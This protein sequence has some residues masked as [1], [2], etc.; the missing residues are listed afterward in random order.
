MTGLHH[1]QIIVRFFGIFFLFFQSSTVW[2]NVISSTGQQ[3]ITHMN[4]T[5][6]LSPSSFFS[7]IATDNTNLSDVDSSLCGANFC[8]DTTLDSSSFTISDKNRYILAAVYLV[9]AIAGAAF[10]G[11][12]VDPLSR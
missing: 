12:F 2:G 5:K 8:P 3:I 9:C 11:I 10:V 1:D 6:P 4:L 7:V